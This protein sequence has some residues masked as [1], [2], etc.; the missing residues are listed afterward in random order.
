[1]LKNYNDDLTD[2][3]KYYD[4]KEFNLAMNAQTWWGISCE[5]DGC[6]HF[7]FDESFLKNPISKW[8]LSDWTNEEN[9]LCFV[10]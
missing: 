3:L 7:D 10:S 8:C 9:T 2:D 5:K 4:E 1:M 6:E